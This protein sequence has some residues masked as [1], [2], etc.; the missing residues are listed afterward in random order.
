MV[1]CAWV[2]LRGYIVEIAVRCG[3]ERTGI[4]SR[5]VRALIRSFQRLFVTRTSTIFES[6]LSVRLMI[7][8]IWMT[9]LII[10]TGV[11][12]RVIFMSHFDGMRSPLVS[13]MFVYRLMLRETMG[14]FVTSLVRMVLLKLFRVLMLFTES[15][16]FVMTLLMMVSLFVVL[17]LLLMVLVF[18]ALP[19]MCS[20]LREIMLT[21][22]VFRVRS[23]MLMMFIVCS[24]IAFRLEPTLVVVGLTRY[25]LLSPATVTRSS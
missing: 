3:R 12:L 21:V 20:V 24:V 19:V 22:V 13:V 2:S 5:F 15:S 9:S 8:Y 14:R 11:V 6:T 16:L 7:V 17:L 25:I 1:G 10:A 23:H 18:I 4:D